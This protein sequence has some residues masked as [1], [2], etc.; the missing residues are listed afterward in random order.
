[1][2]LAVE[3][4]IGWILSLMLLQLM[5]VT[6]NVGKTQNVLI[7]HSIYRDHY[8]IFLNMIAENI[9]TLN[10]TNTSPTMVQQPNTQ[11][12]LG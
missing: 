9:Q 1:M 6:P 7:S 2:T 12:D 11:Q 4:L 10:T 5:L 8:A 3:I